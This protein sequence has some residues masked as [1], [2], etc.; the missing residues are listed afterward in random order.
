[1]LDNKVNIVDREVILKPSDL[2][3][4]F[5][6]EELDGLILSLPSAEQLKEFRGDIDNYNKISITHLAHLNNQNRAEE[7]EYLLKQLNKKEERYK[8][9]STFFVRRS[10]ILNHLDR[11]D[12]AEENVFKATK[13]DQ[14]NYIKF[15]LG[16]MYIL[17]HKEDKAKAIFND[18][19]LSEDIASLI[20]MAYFSVI[21]EKIEEAQ[22]YI[23]KALK[24]DNTDYKSRMFD[25]ALK[26]HNQEWE[27]AIRSF[28]V[29]LEDKHTS[30]A[31]YNNLAIAYWQLDQNKKAVSSLKKAIKYNPFNEQTIMFFAD[32]MYLEGKAGE[33][34][35]ALRQYL[36]HEQK[37]AAVWG[38]L[39]RALYV[40]GKKRG[41]HFLLKEALE[42]LKNMESID[43][44]SE[45]WNHIG[46]VYWGLNQPQKAINYFGQ[47]IKMA[48]DSS[49]NL[50]PIYNLAGLLIERAEYR[51]SFNLIEQYLKSNAVIDTSDELY[52]R[53]R[54]QH[55][56]TLQGLDKQPE[57]AKY[58][59]QLLQDK[60]T[61]FDIKV[62]TLNQLVY[63]HAVIN[64]SEKDTR[65][66]LEELERDV[67]SSKDLEINIYLRSINHIVFCYLLFDKIA[68]AEKI[69][70]SLSEYFH[71]DPFFTATFGMYHIKKGHLKRGK[72]LYLE[73]SRMV[74]DNKMQQRIK[75]RMYFEIGKALV[76]SDDRKNANKEFEKALR[77]K[78][79]FDYVKAQIR[80][81]QKQLN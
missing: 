20:R 57:A 79:G 4:Y 77:L 11:N 47:S 55:I 63:Y 61:P 1:M 43:S 23:D 34:L 78:D 37:S 40:E 6:N 71:K 73:S 24:I 32:V 9:S 36:E 41:N 30:S 16:E 58:C 53:V 35:L 80:K 67:S 22:Q 51:Q 10:S 54:F 44:G 26:L 14:R 64:N 46:L 56:I 45:V 28:R 33:S 38:K 76:L 72:M 50:V 12:E 39:S 48:S 8:D 25:G 62:N 5:G 69:L 52:H 21:D 60:E 70:L 81:Y 19:A 75:Q 7:Y 66:F 3:A 18:E 49:E 27:L 31:L 13:V 2:V 74:R 29:A 68:Q 17:N 65:P 42:C 59:E 15:L